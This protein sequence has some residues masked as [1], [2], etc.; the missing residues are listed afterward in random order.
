[1]SEAPRRDA[2]PGLAVVLAVAALIC[3]TQHPGLLAVS[4]VGD[5]YFF[6][7]KTRDASFLSLWEPRGLV[8]NFYRPWSRELHYW[9]LQHLCGDRVAGWHAYYTLFGAMGAW[10]ALSV[11]L[12][13]APRAAARRLED[14]R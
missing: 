7:G 11:G 14:G 8:S 12:A 5:D 1:V 13:R 4:F 6:L 9:A 2:G 3:W 10:L